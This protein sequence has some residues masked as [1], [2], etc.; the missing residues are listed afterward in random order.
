MRAGVPFAVA[1]DVA[2]F[3]D[4]ESIELRFLLDRTCIAGPCPALGVGGFDGLPPPAARRTCR[5]DAYANVPTF[6]TVRDACNL[7]TAERVLQNTDEAELAYTTLPFPFRVFGVPVTQMWISPNGYLGFGDTAPNEGT[8]TG[9]ARSLGTSDTFGS[10]GFLAFWDDLRTGPQGICI[11]VTGEAPDRVLSLTWKEA[12][13]SVNSAPCTSSDQ[14]RL[15]FTAAIEE[16]SDRMYVGFHEMV[17]TNPSTAD[18][19]RGLTA[20]IGITDDAPRGC[21]ASECM[22]DGVCASG[23]ACHY[24][25]AHVLKSVPVLPTVEL[26]PR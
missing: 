4:E 14:G 13:F 22:P 3:S 5:G 11:G 12:C 9:A 1:R 18:R 23:A 20:V 8:A 10:R 19:A 17:A 2:A 25:E 15:T 24:T 6:F 21:P 7:T 16:T 26:V